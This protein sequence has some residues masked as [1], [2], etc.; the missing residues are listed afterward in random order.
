[1][2]PARRRQKERAQGGGLLLGGRHRG[3][4]QEEQGRRRR[5]LPLLVRF[6]FLNNFGGLLLLLRDVCGRTIDIAANPTFVQTGARAPSRSAT[7]RTTP[8][9]RVRLA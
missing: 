7:G 9:T 3:H 4:G 5:A 6:V 2:V 1:M 8:S